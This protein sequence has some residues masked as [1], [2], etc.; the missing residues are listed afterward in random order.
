MT[1][2]LQQ[3]LARAIGEAYQI[4]REL[5][6]GGMSRLFVANEPQLGRTVVIKVLPPGQQAE[7]GSERFR[8]EAALLAQLRHPHIVPI[9]AAGA[10]GALRW[11]VMPFIAG[12]SVRQRLS[13]AGAFA[14]PEAMALLRDVAGA[15]AHAHAAGVVHRDI[16]PENILLDAGHALL[17]D[18]G[19]ARAVGAATGPE[20]QALTGTGYAVGT[21]GYMAP[22]Q[23]VSE[24]GV[25]G[26][27]DVYALA[28]VGYEML[29]GSRLFAGRSGPDLLAA[30][31]R[32]VPPAP[33][34]L[35]AAIPAALDAVLLRG[36]AKDPAA[37]FPDAAAFRE[38][39][40]A[41]ATGPVRL[42]AAAP[43]RR[44]RRATMA[45]VAGA[46][47]LV[48][49]AGLLLASRRGAATA[50]P[51]GP[52]IAIAPFDVLG[53]K[54]ALWREGA[55]DILARALD[56]LGDLRAIPPSTSI[57]AFTGRAD[58]PSAQALGRAVGA[59]LAVVGSLAEAGPDSVRASAELIEVA[60]G[61][62]IALL[63]RREA[64]DRVDRL[65][66]SLA[67]SI[68][69]ALGQ[70][71]DLGRGRRGSL[72]TT[73]LAALRDFLRAQQFYRQSA[74]DS[75]RA[76]ADRAVAAD[77]TF[78]LALKLAADA[79][80]WGDDGFAEEA[81]I[82]LL[83]RAARH[84][85]GLSPTDSLL[86][87]VDSLYAALQDGTRR[88]DPAMPALG[89]RTAELLATALARFPRDAELTYTLGEVRLH[90]SRHAGLRASPREMLEPF[91]QAI[92]L[93]SSFTPA[94]IH[95][96]E[97]APLRGGTTRQLA[98][99]DALVRRAP[100]AQY[101]WAAPVLRAIEGA[102]ASRAAAI[103]DSVTRTS[104]P[105]IPVGL[106]KL[107]RFRTDA[108]ALVEAV[109]SGAERRP[110]RSGATGEALRQ[111]RVTLAAARGQG[112]EALRLAGGLPVTAP[113]LASLLEPGALDPARQRSLAVA[114]AGSARTSGPGGWPEATFTLPYW[115]DQHDPAMVDSVERLTLRTRTTA[116][117]P[118]ELQAGGPTVIAHFRHAVRGL[119]AAASGDTARALAILDSLPAT[120]SD[121]VSLLRLRVHATLLERAGRPA[122]ALRVLMA[123]NFE[124]LVPDLDEVL[125]SERQARL[126]ASVGDTATAALLGGF[127][128]AWRQ[129][130]AAAVAGR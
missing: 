70:A 78:A 125:F 123:R 64:I 84:A 55:V 124:S 130:A 91:E 111:L 38:A 25:D 51:A 26:R 45:A 33:S 96:V 54:V 72:G 73:N 63:E 93:D 7:G 76:Y 20:H 39:L 65:V 60:S 103:L 57:S 8:R 87:Q 56:G 44:P 108:P 105:G 113:M 119:R 19:I 49:G 35:R 22:E 77:S 117:L 118:R 98:L 122:D 101:A 31:L 11:Y 85:R 69:T 129:P 34:S 27:S 83:T 4:E 68:A 17:A 42:P 24:A 102:P 52:A 104:G 43:A 32:D 58:A 62:R 61:R 48:A 88:R 9:L 126:A 29:T 3:D 15:L 95:A 97:L 6:G 75:A 121:L 18:F 21:I 46:L 67:V 79:R 82:A 86:L 112:D 53:P 94:Y 107:L 14:V 36:L 106:L 10:E 74:F 40:D 1:D 59:T 71:G 5:G 37:R 116:S 23:L 2:S 41:A 80:A 128:R 89:R 47:V 16:K 13:R 12:E 90:H 110:D 127:V 30:H 50:A 92:A 66:D 109:L 28:A 115:A 99:L 120:P 114:W 81:R 100:E